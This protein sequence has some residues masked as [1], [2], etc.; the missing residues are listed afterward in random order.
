MSHTWQKSLQHSE[1]KLQMYWCAFWVKNTSSRGDSMVQTLALRLDRCVTSG[2]VLPCVILG[3]A[4]HLIFIVL[5]SLLSHYWRWGRTHIQTQVIEGKNVFL[6]TVLE[7]VVH[8][9]EESMQVQ[10]ASITLSHCHLWG[11]RERKRKKKEWREGEREREQKAGRAK[12]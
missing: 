6:F 8:H 4:R 10:E 7:G 12:L 1:G 9:G 2:E 5:H 11:E 3:S